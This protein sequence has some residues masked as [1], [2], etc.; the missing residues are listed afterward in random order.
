VARPAVVARSGGPPAE[1]WPRGGARSM[2][3]DAD[4]IAAPPRGLWGPRCRRGALPPC[5]CA[6]QHG[7]GHQP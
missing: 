1:G 3:P 7:A 5:P 2:C 6:G 4:A